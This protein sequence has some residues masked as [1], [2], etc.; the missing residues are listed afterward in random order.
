MSIPNYATIT[1]GLER[2]DVK[3]EVQFNHTPAIG[4]NIIDSPEFCVEPQPEEFELLALV[5]HDGTDLTCLLS[6]DKMVNAII[7][8][9]QHGV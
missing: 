4:G 6:Y 8:E 7:E 5:S 3:L 1:L 2:F 9:L